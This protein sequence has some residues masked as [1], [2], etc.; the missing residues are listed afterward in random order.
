MTS[1]TAAAH[2]QS[3]IRLICL[4]VI[5]VQCRENYH[6]EFLKQFYTFL[7][8]NINW[9]VIAT[10]SLLIQNVCCTFVIKIKLACV[11]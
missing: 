6:F 1:L 3:F 10:D 2:A 11:Y 8:N 9:K 5:R 4:H 7:H